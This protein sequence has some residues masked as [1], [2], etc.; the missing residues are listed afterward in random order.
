M[1]FRSYA[2][3][4]KNIK[5]RSRQTTGRRDGAGATSRTVVNPIAVTRKV[6]L[7]ISVSRPTMKR[8]MVGNFTT[9]TSLPESC[10]RFRV[11]LRLWWP[12]GVTYVAAPQIVL[13]L[14]TRSH[15]PV[16]RREPCRDMEALG[17]DA[18]EG[19]AIPFLL[20][21]VFMS[22]VCVLRLST[23]PPRKRERPGC[24]KAYPQWPSLHVP[25]DFRQ[26]AIRQYRSAANPTTGLFVAA[27]GD[28][29]RLTRPIR[30]LFFGAPRVW[31]G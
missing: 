5:A 28:R 22:H 14:R 8:V 29:G 18:A 31:S 7:R 9:V 2:V 27:T 4:M 24:R 10:C 20:E 26:M 6:E 12:H 25:A 3:A 21:Q 17:R 23:P 15:E 11:H 19:W 13:D 16:A 1:L 30:D